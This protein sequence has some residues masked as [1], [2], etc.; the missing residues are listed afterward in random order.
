MI[1]ADSV[2]AEQKAALLGITTLSR[3]KRMRLI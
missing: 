1:K 2:D 3:A